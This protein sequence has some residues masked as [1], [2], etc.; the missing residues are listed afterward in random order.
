MRFFKLGLP[1]EGNPVLTQVAGLRSDTVFINR[2][3]AEWSKAHAWNAC[4]G[5]PTEGSNP[6]LSARYSPTTDRDT[7]MPGT[8]SANRFVPFCFFY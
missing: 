1:A 4:V 3:V 2:E 8:E 7:H 6:F 5:Q